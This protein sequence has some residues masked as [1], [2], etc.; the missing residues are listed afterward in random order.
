MTIKIC[1]VCSSKYEG[2][3]NQIFC[4]D[5][6]RKRMWDM[7]AFYNTFRKY[8]FRSGKKFL[9]RRNLTIDT[10]EFKDGLEILEEKK[11]GNSM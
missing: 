1:P 9:M 2:R 7:K 5:G 8:Y 11:N 4:D 3:S 10:S 6:C